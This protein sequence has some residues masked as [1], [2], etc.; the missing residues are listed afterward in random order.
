MICRAREPC[1]SNARQLQDQGQERATQD[2]RR[3][4]SGRQTLPELNGLGTP[5]LLLLLEKQL[6]CAVL[7]KTLLV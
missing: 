3:T 7:A 5:S 1:T 4:R 6:V 2:Q